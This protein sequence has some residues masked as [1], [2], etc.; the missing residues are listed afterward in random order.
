MWTQERYRHILWK[1]ICSDSSRS[2]SWLHT[3]SSAWTFILIF[4]SAHACDW[5]KLDFPW[6]LFKQIIKTMTS[7]E[8]L[9]WGDF[10][11]SQNSTT[12]HTY[13]SVTENIFCLLLPP[14]A[15]EENRPSVQVHDW[16]QTDASHRPLMYLS[17]WF[18]SVVVRLWFQI[19]LFILLILSVF[20]IKSIIMDKDCSLCILLLCIDCCLK[21]VLNKVF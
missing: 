17:C 5:P 6:S 2:D 21:K 7:L 9:K 18:F 4:K 3:M 1:Y 20:L 8:L 11:F 16:S 14:K 15:M 19:C 10:P 12:K 13:Y